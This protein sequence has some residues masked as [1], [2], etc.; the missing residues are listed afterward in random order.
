MKLP[1]AFLDDIRNFNAFDTHS[2]EQIFADEM[3]R[4]IIKMMIKM[5]V[6]EDEILVYDPRLARLRK[7][8]D[9]GI[10]Y[11]I[12]KSS[13]NGYDY[14]TVFE[15]DGKYYVLTTYWLCE[16]SWAKNGTNS[17]E[18]QVILNN[19]MQIYNYL[20]MEVRKPKSKRR[21]TKENRN[22]ALSIL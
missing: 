11:R 9:Y 7:L 17:I 12:C 22:E 2:L 19:L 21:F 8:D 5:G 1:N 15:V 13:N 20:R 4:S 14:T 16:G 18:M 6:E 10:S 3:A